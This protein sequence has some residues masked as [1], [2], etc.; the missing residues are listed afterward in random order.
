MKKI[1]KGYM[2]EIVSW[3]N[4]ADYYR[5]MYLTEETLQGAKNLKEFLIG[6]FGRDYTHKSGVGNAGE[7][8]EGET[9]SKIYTYLEN[10]MDN[11]ICSKI[12]ED[13]G[14]LDLDEG[15]TDYDIIDSVNEY[16]Y[17]A[18]G[19]TDTYLF[20]VIES[21]KIYHVPETIILEEI[22]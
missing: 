16:A 6:L 7:W 22:E 13:L 12:L 3:E 11:L 19:G 21:V 10:N 9:A 2:L 20:R 18:M 14:R 17:D 1:E 4:D 5:T 8:E 15:L